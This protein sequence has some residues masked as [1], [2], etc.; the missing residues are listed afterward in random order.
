MRCHTPRWIFLMY[1]TF[2]NGPVGYFQCLLLWNPHSKK[3][4]F[5]VFYNIQNSCP[6]FLG[7]EMMSVYCDSFKFKP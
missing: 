2:P 6:N 4:S 3:C 5:W 7:I 1:P